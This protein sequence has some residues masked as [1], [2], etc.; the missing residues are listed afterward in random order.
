MKPIVVFDEVEKNFYG[1]P[2]LRKVSFTIPKGQIIGIIGTNGS[3]KSTI[4]KLMAGLQR[5]SRG[6]VLLDGE[7]AKRLSSRQVAFLPERDVYYPGQTVQQALNFYN[8][9]FGDFDLDKALDMV[10]IFDLELGQKVAHLSKGNRARL[11]M[12]LALAR[13]VPLIVMDEPLSGLDPLVRESIVRSVIASV[14]P[15]NQTLV[16]T[17]HEVDEVEPLL[18]RAMVIKEGAL[19]GYEQVE[20]IHSDFG[21][22]LTGWMRGL[23][24]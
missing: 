9:M 24:K 17:T 21:V 3:G 16:M 7:E 4:L 11:K 14:D 6:R 10:R 18:D 2:A 5:P 20:R 12:V 22:G 15:V 19:I 8:A 1:K 13:Q 23:M